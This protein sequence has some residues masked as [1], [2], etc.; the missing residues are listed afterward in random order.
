MF[1]I[2]FVEIDTKEDVKIPSVLTDLSWKL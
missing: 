1:H 2:E